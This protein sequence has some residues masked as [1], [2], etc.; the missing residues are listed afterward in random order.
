MDF[1]LLGSVGVKR[2]GKPIELSGAKENTLLA[3][4]LL[5]RGK[6]VS[7][8]RL[9]SL[10]WGWNPPKTVN[11]QIYTYI[12]RLR[13]R[14]GAEVEFIR[15]QPGYLLDVRDAQVDVAEFDRLGR[16]GGT[17]LEE[18]RHTEAAQTLR[19]ALAL[20]S[21]GALANVT[22]QLAQAYVPQ[23]E[24]AWAT[25]LEQRIEADLALGMHQELIAELTGLVAAYPVRERLR[26]HL[27]TALY[28]CGRQADALHVYYEG[29]QVLSDELGID[30]SSTL[31][32]AYQAVLNGD[33]DASPQREADIQPV[34]RTGAPVSLPPALPDFVGRKELLKNLCGLLRPANGGIGHAP[35]RR[36]L[37][38][39]M[40]GVGKTALALQAAHD[41]RE[42]FPDGQIYV[43]LCD[44]DGEPKETKEILVALLRAL[45]ERPDACRE[46]QDDLVRLFR[47]ATFGKRVLV[48]LDNA[49]GDL[50]LEPLLP[51]T[52][53]P[54]VL[55]TGRTRIAS[56]AE[57][58]TLV[59]NPMDDVDA[60]LLLSKVAGD[61]RT[62]GT[63]GE[64]E[65][66]IAHCAGL[67]LALRIVGTR[68]AARPQW[69]ASRLV[70]RLSNPRTR[71]DE[72]HVGDLDVRRS[73]YLSVNRLPAE[74]RDFLCRLAP[75]G[76]GAVS[77]EEIAAKLRM[78]VESAERMMEA[79]VDVGL[80]NVTGVDHKER[81]LYRL[82]DLL[83]LLAAE[84]VEET[85]AALHMT[86][87]PR[88]WTRAVTML[89]TSPVR[90]P[91]LGQPS[92]VCQ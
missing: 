35:S 32:D 75:T 60:F 70:A 56:V 82:H 24:E 19:E 14:L 23:L 65:K 17:A 11:A 79:L 20:W 1:Q 38:V 44:A 48:F 47:A 40:G 43:N 55:I 27:M 81:L 39:G 7:D 45:G 84:I 71:L 88:S 52:A 61:R 8:E 42:A 86:P 9:I 53:E 25:V 29:R 85:P 57:A 3:A 83:Y 15:R 87:P 59:V 69:S 76:R 18:G 80:L 49:V 12:S 54:T 62:S 37:V 78:P 50:Q 89:A 64:T 92:G 90:L 28:R 68:L 91:M 2:G 30:P 63:S 21:G 46:S 5:A 10:L 36:F 72:L 34:V 22:P 51:N 74:I 6:V 41:M 73:L 58:N 16:C 13:K 4:L 66:I 26:A 33:L 67:P 77:P 31:T